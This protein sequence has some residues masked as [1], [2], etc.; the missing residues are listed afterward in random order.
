MGT[1]GILFV[2][3]CT[4]YMSVWYRRI[5]YCSYRWTLP[6]IQTIQKSEPQLVPSSS[7]N[8]NFTV[9]VLPE[10]MSDVVFIL[11]FEATDLREG[12]RYPV[13]PRFQHR[14]AAELQTP[15]I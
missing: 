3:I 2:F 13:A 8:W 7:A 5:H 15:K 11:N 1:A 14:C 4:F 6:R 12:G 10:L 9:L